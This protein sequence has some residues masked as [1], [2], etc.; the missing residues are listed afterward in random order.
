MQWYSTTSDCGLDLWKRLAQEDSSA[1]NGQQL[2]ASLRIAAR[3]LIEC[4]ERCVNASKFE[5]M[6]RDAERRV[7][8]V[9]Q[10]IVSGENKLLYYDICHRTQK[11][12][13]LERDTR[14]K[15]TAPL[16]LLLTSCVKN[17]KRDISR[18]MMKKFK[19]QLPAVYNLVSSE[20][21]SDFNSYVAYAERM[22]HSAEAVAP[23]GSGLA[24]VMATQLSLWKQTAL[25][26]HNAITEFNESGSL[27]PET[28]IPLT[29]SDAMVHLKR[30]RI[31]GVTIVQ[32]QSTCLRLTLETGEQAICYHQV[33]PAFLRAATFVNH[34][35]SKHFKNVTTLPTSSSSSSPTSPISLFMMQKDTSS[36]PSICIA[37]P[38]SQLVCAQILTVEG[39]LQQRRLSFKKVR[40]T[41]DDDG[42]LIVLSTVDT[43][44]SAQESTQ[45]STDSSETSEPSEPTARSI[46]LNGKLSI[47]LA[48]REYR[49]W[50]C[51]S[52]DADDE[53]A[54][55]FAQLTP[56]K[57]E[58]YMLQ[59]Y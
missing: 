43:K 53:T 24:A 52:M 27:T 11:M 34:L 13:F 29:S 57:L 9:E 22:I 12:T 8:P 26:L 6:C 47:A 20:Y 23:C 18:C 2:P 39:F 59:D 1:G 46:D 30:T 38:A 15:L 58:E 31:S 37:S 5:Y 7:I 33:N 44:N 14:V 41:V 19:K 48:S 10:H 49:Y 40:F 54:R 32:E 21:Q 42:L 36:K 16:F 3:C 28:C 4:Y 25:R 35:Y 50:L 17:Y 51:R 45:E 55:R 56:T